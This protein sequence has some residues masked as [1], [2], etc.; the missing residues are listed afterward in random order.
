[1]SDSSYEPR[2]LSSCNLT[3]TPYL[4]LATSCVRKPLRYSESRVTDRNRSLSEWLRRFEVGK[5]WAALSPRHNTRE[6]EDPRATR[7]Q[8]YVCVRCVKKDVAR[9]F[10]LSPPF[11]SLSYYSHLLFSCGLFFF[12]VF[13]FWSLS[14][15]HCCYVTFSDGGL[16]CVFLWSPMFFLGKVCKYLGKSH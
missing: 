3:H 7:T 2:F 9:L 10:L 13:V 14:F 8:E 5:G 4:T 16:W 12:Y 15:L 1:M 6:T 11:I